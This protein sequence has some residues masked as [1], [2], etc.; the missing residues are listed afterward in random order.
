MI[1]TLIRTNRKPITWALL[2]AVAFIALFAVWYKNIYSD[3]RSVFNAM[4]ENSLRTSSVTKRIVQGD[5]SQA[6]DQKVRLQIGEMHLVQGLTE[7]SQTGV[8]SAQ[9]TTESIG[10]PTSDF[11]RYRSINTDQKS[12]A[13]GELD[14]S[15][16]IGVWGKTEAEGETTG[17]LYNE[18]TLGVIPIGNLSAEDRQKLMNLITATDVYKVEYAN[19][20]RVSA[21]GRPAYEYTVKVL[22]VAYVTLLKNYAQMV[23]LTQLQDI[24]PARYE[25]SNAIEFTVTVDIMTRRLATTT[26]QNGR[27]ENYISYGGTTRVAVPKETIP[28]EELQQRI[29]EVQ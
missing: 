8:A 16:V 22:P 11:V 3:P 12:A 10:T 23:G 5:E 1:R 20:K 7:L 19:V 17:E 24:D 25:N 28:V 29:Q 15:N 4:I 2:L 18:S 9:V 27:Q 14:F 21:N 26:Y 13:G 6:L